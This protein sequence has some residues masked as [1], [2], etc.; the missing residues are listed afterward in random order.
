[1]ICRNYL[2]IKPNILLSQYPSREIKFDARSCKLAI[3]LMNERNETHHF[4][5]IL[6]KKT[7]FAM[8]N[9]F[10]SCSTCKRYHRAFQCHCLN[11]HYAEWLLPQNRIEQTGCTT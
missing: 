11:H 1:M 8:H 2:L 3:D 5:Y 7:C 4:I 9:K 6:S 10:R